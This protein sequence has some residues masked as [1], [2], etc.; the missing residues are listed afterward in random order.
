VA[1][2]AMGEKSFGSARLGPVGLA[3][4]TACIL[5]LLAG[6]AVLLIEALSPHGLTL[7]HH[8]CGGGGY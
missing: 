4:M 3:V 5:M 2:Q 6:T 7:C 8:N 1:A